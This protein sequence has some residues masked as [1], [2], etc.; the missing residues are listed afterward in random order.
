VVEGWLCHA[1]V[2]VGN[3][4]KGSG[5][6]HASASG[7]ASG[8][9]NAGGG[10][11]SNGSEKSGSGKAGAPANSQKPSS[12]STETEPTDDCTGPTT[13]AKIHGQE[14]KLV[15]HA[16]VAAHLQGMLAAGRI[17]N[18]TARA[19]VEAVFRQDGR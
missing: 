10:E 2:A 18:A 13:P 9:S 16:K 14:Q 3:G 4:A 15:A 7:K 6:V 11:K 8:S 12:T 19:N 17:S 5:S 1:A